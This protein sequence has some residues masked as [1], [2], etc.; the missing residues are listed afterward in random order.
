MFTCKIKNN[1]SLLQFTRKD[2]QNRNDL[3]F[4]ITNKKDLNN[5]TDGSS[6]HE[7]L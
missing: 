3:K 7:E 1:F 5:Q 6:L 4:I 2:K